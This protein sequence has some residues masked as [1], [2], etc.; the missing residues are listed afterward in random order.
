MNLIFFGFFVFELLS[1]VIGEGFK[2]YLRDQFNWFDSSVVLVSAVDVILVYSNQNKKDGKKTLINFY[3]NRIF[4]RR[5]NNCF[6]SYEAYKNLLIR[7]IMEGLLST[8]WS[9][10]SF[11]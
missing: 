7:K 2:F 6:K 11:T 3:L 10:R 4:V 1:K 5:R 9:D 8:A